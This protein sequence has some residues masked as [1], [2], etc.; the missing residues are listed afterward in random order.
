MTDDQACPSQDELIEFAE[1]RALPEVI[2]RIRTHL[3]QCLRCRDAIAALEDG[4]LST[5]RRAPADSKFHEPTQD[6]VGAT[7]SFLVDENFDLRLLEDSH[8]P[9]ALGRLGRYE[10]FGVLGRGG[11]GVVLKGKDATLRRLVAIKIM[12]RGLAGSSQAR[13]RFIREARAAAAINHPNVV[14]IHS[15]EEHDGTPF[16]VMELVAGKSLREFIRATPNPDFMDVLRIGAQIAQ[17]LAA[18]HAQGIIHRDVKP[19]NIMLEDGV[20]RVKITDFGLARVTLENGDHTTAHFGAGTPAYMAPEQVRGDK[21]DTRADLFGLGCVL[22]AMLS[23][24]SPFHGRTSLEMAQ[25]IVEFDPPNLTDQNHAVPRFLGD[26]IERLLQKDPEKRFQSAAEVADV[27]NRHLTIL[28]ATPTD[29]IPDVLRAGLR[30]KTTPRAR[31]PLI[32]AAALALLM[33]IIGFVAGFPP[34]QRT[35]Q[36][37]AG[38]AGDRASAAKSGS[39]TN[40]IAENSLEV[41]VARDGSGGFRSIQE[42][43]RHVL[44]GGTVFVQDDAVYDE[45]VILRDRAKFEGVRLVARRRAVLQSSSPGA[46]VRLQGVPGVVVRGFRIVAPQAQHAIEITGACAGM[47][48]GDIE[49]ER[50]ENADGA[51][52]ALA[53]IYLHRG[54]RGDT[55]RPIRLD[56]LEIQATVVGVVVEDDLPEHAAEV[57][58][59]IVLESSRV[60]GRGDRSATL[61]ALLLG[62]RNVNLRR[63]LMANG[64]CALSIS[65]REKRMPQ[66]WH[67]THNTCYHLSSFAIWTGP[68]ERPPSFSVTDNL[69]VDVRFV[70]DQLLEA[71]SRPQ[72][73]QSFGNNCWVSPPT[74]TGQQLNRLA[75]LVDSLPLLSTDASHA[76]FLKPDVTRLSPG[77]TLNPFPG[78][79]DLSDLERNSSTP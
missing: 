37:P 78:R 60:V 61:V 79:H 8:E 22:H 12:G 62:S 70:A 28:N 40:P 36:G 73:S 1:G 55:D 51:D 17:G 14:T 31:R 72:A 52:H 5:T 43:L 29:E 50:T 16:L 53:A 63:N 46:V 38:G 13:R 27:L 42:G 9:G 48:V 25:R 15:V 65:T 69:L 54:A 57:P 76:D 56:E 75:T 77:Q 26:V 10:I 39:V 20:L 44:P 32:I 19:G 59:D 67:F 6:D 74:D 24:H 41:T 3:A 11:Y 47:E 23:G 4:P 30:Q 21:I 68:G 64:V 71:A 49:V 33:T 58:R 34:W 2:E 7:R 66:N 18:A 35:G 45:P